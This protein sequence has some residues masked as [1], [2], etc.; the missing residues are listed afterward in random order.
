VFGGDVHFFF[1]LVVDSHCAVF[2]KGEGC[3]WC[4]VVLY[5]GC[6]EAEPVSAYAERDFVGA[7]FDYG[8]LCAVQSVGGCVGAEQGGPGGPEF[9]VELRVQSW[10]FSER[11]EETDDVERNLRNGFAMKGSRT[12]KTMRPVSVAW[13]PRLK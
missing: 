8:V 4:V 11:P 1:G 10:A 2:L 9:G 13:M 7:D 12:A 3:R 5:S 6:G